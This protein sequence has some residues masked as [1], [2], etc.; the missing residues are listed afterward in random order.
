MPEDLNLLAKRYKTLSREIYFYLTLIVGYIIIMT[1]TFSLANPADSNF[2]FVMLLSLLG[3]FIAY[4]IL[5]LIL[6]SVLRNSAKSKFVGRL[7]EELVVWKMKAVESTILSIE[8]TT[9]VP[10]VNIEIYANNILNE[11]LTNA[12]SKIELDQLGI[13]YPDTVYIIQQVLEQN[14]SLGKYYNVEQFFVK[15]IGK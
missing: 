15:N 2:L 7:K 4:A 14:P 10:L 9:P 6:F 8:T 5:L 3:S 1:L 13:F 12:F 11:R